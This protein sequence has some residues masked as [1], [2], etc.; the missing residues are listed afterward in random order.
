MPAYN[1][2]FC[3]SGAVTPQKRQYELESYYP[4]ASLVEAATSQSRLGVGCKRA[5]AL[6][7]RCIELKIKCNVIY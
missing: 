7:T 2:R 5:R 1:G 3:E 6:Q 4:A